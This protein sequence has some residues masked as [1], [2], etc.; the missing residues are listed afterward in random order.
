MYSKTF[1]KTA[2]IVLLAVLIFNSNGVESTVYPTVSWIYRGSNV[3]NGTVLQLNVADTLVLSCRAKAGNTLPSKSTPV[4]AISKNGLVTGFTYSSIDQ[5]SG[6]ITFTTTSNGGTV[7]YDSFNGATAGYDHF[8]TIVTLPIA[9]DSGVYL[10]SYL[11]TYVP[12]VRSSE[13]GIYYCAYID[14]S[15]TTFSTGAA[16]MASSGSLEIQVITKTSSKS[17]RLARNRYL[18]YSLALIGASKLIL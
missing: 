15:A 6:A 4:Y 13:A 7:I 14:G 10:T 2:L 18:E 1:L 3:A 12:L 8:V 11:T 9:T 5:S 16:N 17:S